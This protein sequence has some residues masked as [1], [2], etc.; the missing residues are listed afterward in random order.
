MPSQTFDIASAARQNIHTLQTFYQ[1]L[2]KTTPSS[3][4]SNFATTNLHP[5]ISFIQFWNAGTTGTEAWIKTT[6]VM[7]DN[8]PGGEMAFETLDFQVVWQAPDE[9]AVLVRSKGAFWRKGKEEERLVCVATVFYERDET[10]TD[11]VRMV[12]F[13]ETLI[14]DETTMKC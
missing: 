10:A 14:R 4:I 8:C 11:G 1:S 3:S 13:Q 5:K 9:R 7:R 12:S 2:S 6:E